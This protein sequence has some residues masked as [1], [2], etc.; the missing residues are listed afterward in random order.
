MSQ[1]EPRELTYQHLRLTLLCALVA[2]AAFFDFWAFWHVSDFIMVLFFAPNMDL[3]TQSFLTLLL[4]LAGYLARPLGGWLIGRYGDAHGRKPALI[5]S[6]FGVAFFTL[7]M[8]FLPTYAAL[9][10]LAIIAFIIARLGQG[11]AFGS[12]LPTLWVYAAEHMPKRNIGMSGGVIIAG[13]LAGALVLSFGIGLLEDSLSQRQMLS[14]GWRLPFIIGGA[15][16]LLA[17]S[18][19]RFYDETPVFLQSQSSDDMPS[20]EIKSPWQSTLPLMVASWFFA[21]VVVVLVQLLSELTALAFHMNNGLMDISL[22]L[23]T[24]FLMIG[25]VFFGFLSDRIGITHLLIFGSGL[26]MVLCAALFYDLALGG[27]MMLLSFSLTG[28]VAG[29]IGIIPALMVRLTTTKQRLT[30]I[31]SCYSIAFALVGMGVPALLGFL[32]FY[33]SYAP[34]LYVSFAC[35]IMM[36]MG[37]YLDNHLRT[38][39]DTTPK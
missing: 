26:L 10:N 12:Q 38:Q 6:L 2:G 34:A 14:Y 23:S 29:L 5:L 39:D 9:G 20:E 31:C 11:M 3:R 37:F 17:L 7:V 30:S 27:H 13:A 1:H 32:T 19:L 24:V 15:L 16:S 21:S 18:F 33:A 4:F 36:F 28:F 25:S 35:M 22:I 8:A